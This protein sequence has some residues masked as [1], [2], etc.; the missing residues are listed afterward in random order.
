MDQDLGTFRYSHKFYILNLTEINNMALI[1]ELIRS[2]KSELS[3][4]FMMFYC[5]SWL[6]HFWCIVGGGRNEAKNNDRV[7]GR[8]VSLCS[9]STLLLDKKWTSP[10]CLGSLWISPCFQERVIQQKFLSQMILHFPC[11]S[12][13]ARLVASLTRLMRSA[14]W[15]GRDLTERSLTRLCRHAFILKWRPTGG[16][17]PMRSQQVTSKILRWL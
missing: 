13:S 17:G 3:L 9:V 10:Q 4:H 12:L 5:S 6:F 7:R 11:A 8:D 1:T 16:A 2:W 15:P 14:R